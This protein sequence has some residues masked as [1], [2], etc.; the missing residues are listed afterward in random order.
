MPRW[1]DNFNDENAFEEDEEEDLSTY[2]D[3]Q[4]WE[5]EVIFE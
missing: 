4:D 2:D 3:E 5:P 1:K